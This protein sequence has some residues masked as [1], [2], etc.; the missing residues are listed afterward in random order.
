MGFQWFYLAKSNNEKSDLE[1][2]ILSLE[3]KIRSCQ[4]DDFNAD[5]I[6]RNLQNFKRAY[7][8]L[9]DEDKPQCLQPIL[10]DV[11]VYKDRIILNIF[12]LPEFTA[13][14]QLRSKKLPELCRTNSFHVNL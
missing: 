11:I 14:S 3:G 6:R 8:A 13:G 7:N 4:F 1:Q 2:K 9:A 12:D 5:V 10:K